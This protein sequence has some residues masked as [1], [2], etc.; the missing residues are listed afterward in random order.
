MRLGIYFLVAGIYLGTYSYACA[1]ESIYEVVNNED[2]A[3]FSD[4]VVLG[5]DIDEPDSDGFTPL[6]IAS[7][8]GK[9]HFVRFLVDNGADVNRCSY[10]GVT[11]LHRAAQAGNNDVIDILLDAGANINMPDFDGKTPL[12]T[13]VEAG[14][15]FTVELLV[16]RRADV[17]TRTANNETV[18]GIAEKKRFKEIADFL[19]LKGARK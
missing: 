12:V 2:T 7:A 16:A 3:T 18:L 19:R 1:D 4:M 17:N 9:T 10:N 15:R 5:Y 8:L 13:A 14:R 6:M 11:S